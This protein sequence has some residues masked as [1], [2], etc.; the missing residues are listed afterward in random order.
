MKAKT[1]F[2]LVMLFCILFQTTAQNPPVAPAQKKPVILTGGTI[3]TGTGA[4]I[5]NG[6]IAF[7]R[8]QDNLGGKSFGKP[9]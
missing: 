6:L 3:H 7:C 8:R 9:A 1:I 4:V 5:G 2:P